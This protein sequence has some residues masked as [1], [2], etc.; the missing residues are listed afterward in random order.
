[1]N[2][3]CALAYVLPATI[4]YHLHRTKHGA[5]TALVVSSGFA[6]V[7]AVVA[8]RYLAIPMYVRLYKIPLAAILKMASAT[9][10]LVHSLTDFLLLTILPFNLIKY[11]IVSFLTYLVY[12]KAS[13]ALQQ[14]AEK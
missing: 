2:L 14:I 3:L 7:F 1:M 5:L 4:F 10:P 9:N 12:K 8:N 6:S 11:T 13:L